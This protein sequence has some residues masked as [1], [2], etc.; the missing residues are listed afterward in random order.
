MRRARHNPDA[1]SVAIPH[2]VW[3]DFGLPL[4]PDEIRAH[5]TFVADDIIESESSSDEDPDDAEGIRDDGAEGTSAALSGD[6]NEQGNEQEGVTGDGGSDAEADLGGEGWGRAPADGGDDGPGY[7]VVGGA[8]D[9]GTGAD[10]LLAVGGLGPAQGQTKSNQSLLES[11]TSDQ[12]DGESTSDPEFD[13]DPWKYPEEAPIQGTRPLYTVS[14]ATIEE[15]ATPLIPHRGSDE[16]EAIYSENDLVSD[17]EKQ[18][19]PKADPTLRP[20]ERALDVERRELH[21]L[22]MQPLVIPNRPLLDPDLA[23]LDL[24]Q[25]HNVSSQ[26]AVNAQHAHY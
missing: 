16:S 10:S 23:L 12:T 8:A 13:N 18:D 4:P 6:G 17:A 20:E 15:V 9:P 1:E 11:D 5:G 3:E 26:P 2:R 7:S 19:A 22:Y 21:R 25:T 14:P 24:S